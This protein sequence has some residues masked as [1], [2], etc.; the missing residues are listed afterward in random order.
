[1]WDLNTLIAMNAPQATPASLRIYDL[2]NG[3]FALGNKGRRA[4]YVVRRYTPSAQ[5][6]YPSYKGV[7]ARKPI[8]PADAVV[9]P[10]EKAGRPLLRALGLKR[11]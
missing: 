3:K 10:R 5:G 9:V 8:I 1:M 4:A 6:G 7:Q 11:N 2:G